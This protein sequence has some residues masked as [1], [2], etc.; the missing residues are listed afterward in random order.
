MRG[1]L[2][3]TTL[4]LAAAALLVAAGATGQWLLTRDQDAQ[5]GIAGEQR[6]RAALYH[7]P[8]HPTMVSN[9]PGDCPICGMRLVPIEEEESAEARPSA[10]GRKVIYQST[11]NPQEI[12]DRPGKDSMG[13]EMVPVEV[14]EPPAGQGAQVEGRATVSVPLAKQQLIGVRTDTVKRA[15][16]VRTIRTIGRVTYDETRLHHVHTKVGG[17]IEELYANATGELVRKGEP[18][19]TIYSPE[20]LASAQEYLLAVRARERR[21]GA[22]L[23]GIRG[24]GDALVES[25]RQRLLLFDVTE[26]QLREIEVTGAAPRT[27][28]LYAPTTGHIIVRN[29]LAGEKIESGSN[30]LDIAD[31]SRVWVLAD[32]YEYELPFVREGQ[33]ATMTLSYLPG[34]TFEGRIALVSPVLSEMTRTVKARLEFPNPDLTLKPEMFG[35]VAIQSDSGEGL[36]VAESAVISTGT[37]DVVF[38]DRGGGYFEPREVKLGLRLPDSVEILE[39]LAEGERVVVSGNFLI[40]SESRLKSALSAAT[41]KPARDAAGEEAPGHVH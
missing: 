15:R 10:S 14:D 8:M 37:R 28:T 26:D 36:T 35:E 22:T 25:A 11:M 6:P 31:L 19:L 40:D 4:L 2:T 39:G 13:M 30:L 38:V 29:V 12:S 9:Q 18:V 7:C 24:S 41:A 34:R 16:L 27:M 3:K 33:R 23:P 1:T 17:W 5:A 21:A 32:V 20:L